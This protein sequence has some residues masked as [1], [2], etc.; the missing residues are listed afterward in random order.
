MRRAGYWR[1]LP[2]GAA[3][4]AANRMLQI[5]SA[6]SM[7]AGSAVAGVDSACRGLRSGSSAAAIAPK[8]GEECCLAFQKSTWTCHG[9]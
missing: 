4:H 6:S 7:A 1:S 8:A 9:L 3:S 2:G 5:I